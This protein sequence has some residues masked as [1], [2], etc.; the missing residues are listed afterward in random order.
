M[1]GDEQTAEWSYQLRVFCFIYM[2]TSCMKEEQATLHMDSVVTEYPSMV[3]EQD[4][5]C[6][7]RSTETDHSPPFH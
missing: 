2:T 1:E 3:D 6:N 7:A 4:C 5:I